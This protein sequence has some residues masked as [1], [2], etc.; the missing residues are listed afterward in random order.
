M[1]EMRSDS[2]TVSN[3]RSSHT[4][5]CK[6]QAGT[7]SNSRNLQTDAQSSAHMPGAHAV[8]RSVCA[9]SEQQLQPAPCMRL[10]LRVAQ[11]LQHCCLGV[12]SANGM[13]LVRGC[14]SYSPC[15]SCNLS[16]CRS[17]EALRGV[18]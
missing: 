14:T 18:S 12:K 8:T 10:L 16:S 15:C 1:P 5:N 17:G 11:L 2:M 6:Q 4:L 9:A 3:T 7:L 13:Q